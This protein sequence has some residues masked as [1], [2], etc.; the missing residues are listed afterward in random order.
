MCAGAADCSEKLY[1][2]HA[3]SLGATELGLIKLQVTVSAFLFSFILSCALFHFQSIISK[4]L[5]MAHTIK[6]CGSKSGGLFDSA[7][8]DVVTEAGK[9]FSG[10]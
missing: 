7:L 6:M 5:K 1:H 8:E 3:L 4:Q 2:D 9:Y 10:T